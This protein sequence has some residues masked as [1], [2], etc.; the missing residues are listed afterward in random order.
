[1]KKV[2]ADIRKMM[3]LFDQNCENYCAIPD[4]KTRLLRI[5][6]LR[7]EYHEYLEGEFNNDRDEIADGLIDII[8]I[9][10]GTLLSYGYP[11]EELWNEV[12]RSNMNKADPVTGKLIRRNDGKVLKHKNWVAPD[13]KG[14]IDRFNSNVGEVKYG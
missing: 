4:D 9:A 11:V 2:V 8:V 10:V 3:E 6:L 14:I 7:E 12:F 13:I 1:M 5:N